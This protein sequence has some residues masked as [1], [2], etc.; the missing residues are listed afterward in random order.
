MRGSPLGGVSLTS[1]HRLRSLFLSLMLKV[2]SGGKWYLAKSRP[3]VI[4][5]RTNNRIFKMRSLFLQDIDYW[6]TGPANEHHS[7]LLTLALLAH[8]LGGL[9]PIPLSM[10]ASP[11]WSLDHETDDKPTIIIIIIIAI[12]VSVLGFISDTSKFS[13][14]FLATKIP[15]RICE[16]ICNAAVRNSYDI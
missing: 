1:F 12:E 14:S 9:G 8:C 2:T 3:C 5:R 10:R 13:K 4:K 16:D 6:I 11:I 15:N 7:S